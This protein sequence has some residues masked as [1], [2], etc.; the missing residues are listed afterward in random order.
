LKKRGPIER[1][2]YLL[3]T[4]CGIGMKNGWAADHMSKLRI[5]NPHDRI[6]IARGVDIRLDVFLAWMNHGPIAVVLLVSP[7]LVWVKTC[8]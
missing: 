5:T 7:W 6:T 1:L 3:S 2:A 8:D 4:G